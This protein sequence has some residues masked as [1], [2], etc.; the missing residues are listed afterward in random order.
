MGMGVGGQGSLGS[1]RVA[2]RFIT[3]LLKKLLEASHGF[4]SLGFSRTL[5][6]SAVCGA[7]LPWHR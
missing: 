3:G 4:H 2:A 5:T 1:P 7:K 6:L